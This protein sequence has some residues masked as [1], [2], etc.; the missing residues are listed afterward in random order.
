[1]PGDTGCPGSSPN[2]TSGEKQDGGKVTLLLQASGRP[3]PRAAGRTP[4]TSVLKSAL[5]GGELGSTMTTQ[6]SCPSCTRG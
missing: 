5:E 6:G 1:M 2:P 4:E 3:A